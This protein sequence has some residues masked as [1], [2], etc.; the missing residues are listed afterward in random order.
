[1]HTLVYAML[2]LAVFAAGFFAGRYPLQTKLAKVK[3]AVSNEV[4]GATAEAQSM[5]MRIS[6]VL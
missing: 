1:M 5:L 4:H 3:A 6:K 2:T